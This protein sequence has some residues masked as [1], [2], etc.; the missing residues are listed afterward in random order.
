MKA[1][2][3]R[4]FRDGFLST[5]RFHKIDYLNKTICKNEGTCKE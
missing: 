2:P 3:V 4:A 1:V 5:S